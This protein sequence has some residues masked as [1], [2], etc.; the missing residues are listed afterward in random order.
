LRKEFGGRVQE[1]YVIYPPDNGDFKH[2]PVT[3]KKHQ[4]IWF[5]IPILRYPPWF[6]IQNAG[7]WGIEQVKEV[8]EF[9]EENVQQADYLDTFEGFKPYEILKVKRDLAIMEQ[10][11]PVEQLVVNKST[12][13]E[14]ITEYD[15][16]RNTEFMEVFPEMRKYY[17]DCMKT[18]TKR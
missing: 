8:L 13:Y 4:R 7:H 12:F 9:M 14:F 17:I 15:S 2:P 6:S 16:R 5:D 3:I 10:T 18:F 11:L 1:D